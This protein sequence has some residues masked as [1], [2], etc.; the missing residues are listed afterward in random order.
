[1]S[2]LRQLLGVDLRA[3]CERQ[4][5]PRKTEAMARADHRPERLLPRLRIARRL[6]RKRADPASLGEPQRRRHRLSVSMLACPGAIVLLYA[7]GAQPFEHAPLAVAAPG[8]R[9]GL[10][11][12]IS[13]VVDIA[14]LGKA[15]GNSGD[16]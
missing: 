10:G 9:L 6:C 8:Q 16:I 4:D 12:R 5:R 13:C 2:A 15:L 14:L 3:R 11:E 7:G 1:M